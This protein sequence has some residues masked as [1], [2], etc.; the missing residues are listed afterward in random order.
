M[1]VKLLAAVSVICLALSGCAETHDP[2]DVETLEGSDFQRVKFNNP[3][4]IVDLGAGLWAWPLPMDFD[5]DGDMDLLVSTP[6]VPYRGLHFFENSSGETFPAFEPPVRVF[7]AIRNVQVS[8]IDGQPQVLVPGALL[9]NFLTSFSENPAPL[10]PAD[11]VLRHIT[12]ARF[13]QWKLV[14]F[15]NDGDLDILAGVDDWGDYGWDNA[16]DEAGNWTNGPLHGYVFLIENDQGTY[17]ERGK[18][19]ADGRPIDVYG[20]PTPN[21][22]DF[23]G[24]G[25]L[26]LIAGEFLDRLTWFENIGSREQPEFAAGRF[27][28]NNDGLIKMDLEMIIP[29]SVDWDADGDVDL[30]VGDEDGRVALIEHTG[31]VESRMPVFASPRYFKQKADNL[32]FGA[33]ATPVSV[34]WDGDGDEDLISGNTAGYIAFIENLDGGNP[35]MWA[36]PELLRAG[37]EVIRIMAGNNGSIQ[38]PAEAKWGYTTIAVADW[39]GD[40]LKDLIANSI[41]GR[42]IWYR[43]NGSANKPLLEPAQPVQVDWRGPAPKPEWTWWQPEENTLAP[44]WRTT[45]FAI[46]WNGDSRTDLIMLDHEG[47]LSYFERRED[48]MLSA[49]QRIFEGAT[50]SSYVGRHEIADST[51]GLL[52]LN[53]RLHGGSGRRKFT[54][55][56]W[57]QDGDLDLLVNSDNVSWM[58]N[59]GMKDGRIQLTDMGMLGALKLAGHTTSPTIVD[60][61]RDGIPDV[62]AGAEDG[63]F[64]YLENPF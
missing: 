54:F 42:V 7:D 34:D 56:D 4:A 41:W 21:M 53:A 22:A 26:D 32:K 47:Y 39:D 27:L 3:D 60:W 58:R 24:D 10:Y 38:G 57:D 9:E 61:N 62:L 44:Q 6:D 43:N 28:E 19:E 23:D 51:S 29:V 2:A 50:A 36:P 20:A 11:S 35:P 14:D 59:D 8:Y 17:I 45:P 63:H 52:Q 13:N 18:L 40:G 55:A 49:G 15:D 1:R 46:D 25:D 5:G 30:I 31:S 16:Y 48:G 64:Y 12:R 37:D 33:L